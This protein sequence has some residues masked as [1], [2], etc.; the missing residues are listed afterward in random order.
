M[1]RKK[2]TRHDNKRPVKRNTLKSSNGDV[3]ENIPKQCFSPRSCCV[4]ALLSRNSS[5]FMWETESN[6]C[7]VGSA[8]RPIGTQN[9]TKAISFFESLK[10]AESR[11]M[12][13]WRNITGDTVIPVNFWW[14]IEVIIRKSRCFHWR[15]FNPKSR[16]RT[17]VIIGAFIFTNLHCS[18]T[19]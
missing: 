15:N 19:K 1:K 3:P 14:L 7:D 5:P 4:P 13:A 16:S 9:Y 10:Q 17:P 12:P 11:L 8:E 6:S 18:K 2:T